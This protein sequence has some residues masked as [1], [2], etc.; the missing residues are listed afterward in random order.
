MEGR[1]VKLM[2]EHLEN[3]LNFERMASEAGDTKLKADLKNRQ[4]PIAS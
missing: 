1:E 4:R 3:A 2:Q